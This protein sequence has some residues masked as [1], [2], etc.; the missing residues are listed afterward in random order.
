MLSSLDLYK[1]SSEQTAV[2]I[3]VTLLKIMQ[4]LIYLFDA[5]LTV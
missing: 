2:G 5:Y 3:Q 4:I 1:Q